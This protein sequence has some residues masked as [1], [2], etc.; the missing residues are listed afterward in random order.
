MFFKI[1]PDYKVFLYKG[2]KTLTEK[3]PL[4]LKTQRFW[5]NYVYTHTSIH[6]YTIHTIYNI[7]YTIIVYILDIPYFIYI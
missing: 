1:F 7:I 4:S 3:I 5:N 6:I 2:L